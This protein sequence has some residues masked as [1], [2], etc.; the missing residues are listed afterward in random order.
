M[1]PFLTT[2]V[3]VFDLKDH[4]FVYHLLKVHQLFFSLSD[5]K[6]FFLFAA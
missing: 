3:I 4:V 2:V 6:V 1:L 5:N